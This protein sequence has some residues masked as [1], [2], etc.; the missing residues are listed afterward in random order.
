MFFI[1]QNIVVETSQ[2]E[3]QIFSYKYKINIKTYKWISEKTAGKIVMVD[4]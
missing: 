3:H 4:I 1:F 2:S